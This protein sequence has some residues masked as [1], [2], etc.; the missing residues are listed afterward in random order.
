MTTSPAT[1]STDAA[2]VR[3][4]IP[5]RD[6][7]YDWFF[8]VVFTVFIGS[9]FTGDIVNMVGRPDPDSDFFFARVVYHVYAD[10]TDPLLIANPRFLQ[11]GASVSAVV[12]GTFYVL[13]VYA[14]VKGREWIRIPS[15]IYTGMV[16]QTT[17]IVVMVGFTGDAPLF[18]AVCNTAYDYTFTNVPKALAYNL[19]YI[20]VPILLTA[21]MWCPHP[22]TRP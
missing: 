13:L 20:I 16:V 21:R 7:R 14:F 4:P 8:I 12:F 5:L 17:F 19:P 9:S 2:A 10:A 6:R 3:R 15:F 11:V 22:F 18:Q 1:A